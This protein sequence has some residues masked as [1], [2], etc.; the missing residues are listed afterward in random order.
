MQFCSVTDHSCQKS[1]SRTVSSAAFL[2]LSSLT[3]ASLLPF[4]L[5]H[6]HFS[7]R[8]HT[9]ST[10][11]RYHLGYSH[12]HSPSVFSQAHFSLFLS[13]SHFRL[14]IASLLFPFVIPQTSRKLVRVSHRT[15]L[16]ICPLILA[17]S[18]SLRSPSRTAWFVVVLLFNVPELII[19]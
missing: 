5:S 7:T 16:F 8:S 12:I 14:P 9:H 10:F 11:L 6:T 17:A 13:H 3:P 1:A 18:I 15:H 4:L 2:F 19:V